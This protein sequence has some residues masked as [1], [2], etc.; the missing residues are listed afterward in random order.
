MQSRPV[1]QR[2]EQEGVGVVVWKGGRLVAT[3]GGSAVPIR[4]W[5]DVSR[6]FVEDGVA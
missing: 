3:R 4:E 6:S 1:R 5:G 2:E